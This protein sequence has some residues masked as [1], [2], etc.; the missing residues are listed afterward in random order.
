[1][2]TTC[3]VELTEKKLISAPTNYQGFE[4]DLDE[5]TCTPTNKRAKKKWAA[6][7]HLFPRVV[8]DHTFVDLGANF[9]FFCYKALECGAMRATAV[10]GHKQYYEA[11]APAQDLER[12]CE[13]IHARFPQGTHHIGGDVVMCMSLLHHVF[14][15][16]SLGDILTA[17]HNMTYDA[18]IVE[19]I[20]RD[21]R[22][23]VRKGWAGQHPEYNLARFRDLSRRLFR[24]GI[25]RIGE[26]HH[27]TRTIYLLKT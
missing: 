27:D 26:G 20:G 21:D 1:M 24:G 15:K 17:L 16:C 13:W 6:V 7:E 22:A 9:G 18:V 8:E 12:R 25:Y 14:P 19:W 2:P 4:Y 10:E 3:I 23:I 11:M 5:K